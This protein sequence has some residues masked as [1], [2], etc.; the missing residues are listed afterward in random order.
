MVRSTQA[1]LIE[2]VAHFY[3]HDELDQLFRRLEAENEED[4]DA[5]RPSKLRRVRAAVDIMLLRGPTHGSD[6]LEL[7]RILFEE[8]LEGVERA[9]LTHWQPAMPHLLNGLKADG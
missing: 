7:C 3:T 9:R 8:R 6:V 4:W 5:P 1:A 2:V